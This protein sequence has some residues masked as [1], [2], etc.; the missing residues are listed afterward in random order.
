M[1]EQDTK[2]SLVGSVALGT[3]VMIGAGIFA[4]VGQV[5]GLAGDWFPVAFIAGAA[6]AGVSSYAYARYSSVN[7]SAGGIAMLLKDAYGPGV[8]AGSFSLFMYVSMVVAESLLARTFGTYLLRP[9]GLQDSVVLVPLLGV[10]A[11]AAAAVVNLVSNQL[12]ERSALVTAVLKIVGIAVL[13][14]AG[15]IGAAATGAGFFSDGSDSGDGLLGV[16]AAVALCV[17]AYKGFTTI[18]NQ[19]DDLKDAKRNIARSIMISIA[20]CAVLYLLI[21]LSVGA[22]I[23]ASGAIDA[24]DYALAEAAHPLF[25]AWGVGITV[26]VAVIAT[27]SGLLASLFSVSRLYGMLQD[28]KQAPALPARVPHQPL[29]ITA[30]AAIVLTAVF[31][32]GRIAA[33]GVFLYLT[34]DIAV[35]WGVLRRLRDKIIAHRWLPIATIVL[36]V[37]ILAA[38][39]ISKVQ[40]DLLTVGVAAGLAA[41]IFAAQAWVVTR[42]HRTETSDR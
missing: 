6:V 17:L 2:I 31:D 25:G 40:S 37:A 13:A 1:S 11:I 26:A 3:G 10:I 18:T 41:V 42:R 12:V 27:L 39:T 22:S 35:Q 5:A 9:F 19:G 16:V 23:G 29:L 15:L 20:I 30:G 34:M 4:L 38:F 32:L 7:P 24:R 36:D 14:A 21:T 28:M 8:V 33:L